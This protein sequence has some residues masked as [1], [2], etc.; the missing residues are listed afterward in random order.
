MR[1][2][3]LNNNIRSLSKSQWSI[4]REGGREGKEGEGRGGRGGEGRG[5]REKGGE[6]ERRKEKRR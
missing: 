4:L 1:L 6:E 2:L 3:S 5:W